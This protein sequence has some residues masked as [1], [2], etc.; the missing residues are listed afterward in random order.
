MSDEN[1]SEPDQ[2]TASPSKDLAGR[3]S[4]SRASKSAARK[5][6]HDDSDEEAEADDESDAKPVKLQNG[7]G[8]GS[9]LFHHHL[10]FDGAAER[11][12]F[13]LPVSVRN[14]NST[15]DGKLKMLSNGTLRNAGSP[16]T[17]RTKTID[18]GDDSDV[19]SYSNH[20]N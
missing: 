2:A 19:S 14:R 1:D 17:K 16:S 20:F 12:P 8:L 5:Y 13:Q 15:S 11:K 10:S 3:T 18:S 4:H 9:D 6:D 7:G